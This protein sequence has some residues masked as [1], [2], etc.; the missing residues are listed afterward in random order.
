MIHN[1]KLGV[2]IRFILLP[3]KSSFMVTVMVRKQMDQSTWYMHKNSFSWE[4]SRI[5]KE[6]PKTQQYVHT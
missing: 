4:G 6:N 1:N 3:I 2:E 5:V